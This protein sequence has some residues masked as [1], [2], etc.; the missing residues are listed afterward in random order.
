MG[1]P[2]SK[3]LQASGGTPN[4]CDLSLYEGR[5]ETQNDAAM[6]P[7]IAVLS[8]Q[9]QNRPAWERSCSLKAIL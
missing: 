3:A 6:G 5:M 9:V 4:K 2:F 1:L 7:A 8:Y